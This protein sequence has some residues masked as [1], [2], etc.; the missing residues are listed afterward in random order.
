[1]AQA[2][3]QPMEKETLVKKAS[4]SLDTVTS[5]TLADFDT[6]KT[7]LLFQFQNLNLPYSFLHLPVA[8]W[9]ENKD[10]KISKDFCKSLAVTN[11]HAEQS[12][13]LVQNFSGRL[14][15]EEEQLQYLLQ[16]VSQHCKDFSQSL[17]NALL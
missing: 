11:D 4:V 2:I 9:N 12:V 10:F 14:I 3:L 16:V 15:K 8:Q 7:C 1:M 5:K 17:K 6:S 13:A